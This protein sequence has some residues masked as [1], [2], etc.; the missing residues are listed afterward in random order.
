MAQKM[1]REYESL[2]QKQR[3]DY[4]EFEGKKKRD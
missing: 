3:V 4:R 1:K 2:V